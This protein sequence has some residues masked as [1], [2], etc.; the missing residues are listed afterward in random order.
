MKE[1]WKIL[2][3]EESGQGMAEYGLIIS[4][5]AIAL[6]L[7]FRTFQGKLDTRLREIAN[8]I[9]PHT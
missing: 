4:L 9:K 8:E 5:I 6:I 7:T 2:W 3:R 1:V